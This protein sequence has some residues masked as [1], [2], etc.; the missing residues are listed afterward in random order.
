MIAGIFGRLELE[1]ASPA[2]GFAH[3]LFDY[4]FSR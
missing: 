3:L 2:H 1:E 4:S